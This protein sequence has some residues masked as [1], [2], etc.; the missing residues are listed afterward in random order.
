MFGVMSD[1]ESGTDPTEIAAGVYE[2]LQGTR[3]RLLRF[4]PGDSKS[5]ISCELTEYALD[6]ERVHYTALSYAW[7]AGPSQYKLIMN[8]KCVLVRKNL[9][10]FLQHARS[11]AI[12]RSCLFWID[13]LCIDQ[14]NYKERKHQVNLMSKIYRNATQV[15]IWL[16]PSYGNS[17]LAL[18]SLARPMSFWRAKR[19]LQTIWNQSTGI[20]ICGLC[21]RPYWSRLWSK[22][23]HPFSKDVDGHITLFS[24]V[25]V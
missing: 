6:D 4:L 22:S 24:K 14:S 16:G 11:T 18:R 20:G 2:E 25:Y 12:T 1:D 13:A 19:R 15:L 7:G 10:R 23:R 5:E 3:S 17:D 9:W 8:G 21:E